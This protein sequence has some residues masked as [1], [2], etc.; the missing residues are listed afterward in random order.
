MRNKPRFWPTDARSEGNGGLEMVCNLKVVE[1]A[2]LLSGDVIK[3]VV[4]GIVNIDAYR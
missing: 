2:T 3:K 1:G 4:N